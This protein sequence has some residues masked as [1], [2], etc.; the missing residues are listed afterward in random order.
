MQQKS[1]PNEETV[2][3]FFPICYLRE[4]KDRMSSGETFF[5]ES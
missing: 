1:T 2:I 5:P 4:S 3:N